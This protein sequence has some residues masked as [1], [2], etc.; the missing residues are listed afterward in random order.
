MI[1]RT[2]QTRCLKLLIHFQ[3]WSVEFYMVWNQKGKKK[4]RTL[5]IY[6]V[7]PLAHRVYVFFF[8]RLLFF[9]FGGWFRL[10]SHFWI[11][12]EAF[13]LIKGF[14]MN[15]LVKRCFPSACISCWDGLERRTIAKLIVSL[16]C[17]DGLLY[18]FELRLRDNRKLYGYIMVLR[19]GPPHAISGLGARCLFSFRKMCF[20]C[21]YIS[22]S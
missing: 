5:E 6:P 7:F 8:A 4:K 9:P 2:W 12:F 3:F 11:D 21:K 13:Q 14:E 1:S 15:V 19:F 22:A 17:G 20:V 10:E 16:K 18:T